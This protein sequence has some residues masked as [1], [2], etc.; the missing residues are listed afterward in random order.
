MI[1]DP[2]QL[3]VLG[4]LLA[5]GAAGLKKLWVWGWTYQEKVDE[6]VEMTKDRNF[7]RDTALKAMGHTDKA[8]EVAE[9]R[10]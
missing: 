8:L 10:A 2:Q 1:T 5:I 6:V 4:V 9:K 7:W 3:T